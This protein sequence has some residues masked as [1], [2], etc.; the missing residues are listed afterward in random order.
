MHIQFP[1]F[2]PFIL[3]TV[4]LLHYKYDLLLL[5]LSMVELLYKQ[6]M[7]Q[8]IA[9]AQTPNELRPLSHATLL[10]T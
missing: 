5:F 8:S 2:V 4:S 1:P 10:I 9:I 7:Y 6:I 3:S